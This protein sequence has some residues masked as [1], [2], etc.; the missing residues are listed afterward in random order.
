MEIFVILGIVIWV[1]I[2]L[3][4]HLK[5]KPS[6]RTTRDP[7]LYRP[8][9]PTSRR[10]PDTS[11]VRTKREPNIYRPSTSTRKQTRPA[12]KFKENDSGAG[13]LT[14]LDIKDLVDALTGAPLTLSLGLYQCQHPRCRVFYQLH[15]VEVIKSENGGRCVSCQH[16]GKIVN[17]SGRREQ[18]GRNADV[19]A[20]TLENYRQYVG[21]VITFQGNVYTVYN[22]SSGKDYAVMFEN[23]RWTQ[24]FKMVCFRGD[25]E[26]IGGP[27]YLYSLVG[28]QV[29]VRG[30]LIQHEVFGYEIIVS[31][32]AMI[33]G[34]Q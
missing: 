30:L 14:D 29:R 34:V 4:N 28:Y 27:R 33:L 24:G 10:P 13:S 15:S 18:R 16:A 6:S 8:S 22:S 26:K 3:F 7:N 1:L 32:R 31:D 21:Q 11:S 5:E 2:T 9:T 19:S 20:I 17:V 23:K 12:I 25:V